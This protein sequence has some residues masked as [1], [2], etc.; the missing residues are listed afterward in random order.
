MYFTQYLHDFDD[1]TQREVKRWEDRWF[2]LCPP[3]DAYQDLAN[4]FDSEY[5]IVITESSPGL[6]IITIKTHDICPLL[7]LIIQRTKMHG[8]ELIWEAL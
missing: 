3:L 8:V 1:E 6:P 2:P 4:I 5:K 7:F